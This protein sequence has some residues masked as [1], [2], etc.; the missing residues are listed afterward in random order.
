MGVFSN[1]WP[2]GGGVFLGWT[3][4]ANDAANVFGTAVG[5]RIVRWRTASLLCA[6]FV[7][8]GAFLQGSEG[9]RTLSSITHQSI[10]TAVIVSVAAALTGALMTYLKI[11]VSTSQ[12]VV[13]AILGIGLAS[14]DTEYGGLIKVVL[15][16]IGTPIGSM[17]FA[18]LSFEGLAFFLRRVPL[19]LLSRDRFLWMGLLVC[20]CYGAYALGANNVAN[21]TGMFSGLI[22]GVTD[23]VLTLVGGLAIAG[24]TLSFSKRV[25]LNVGRGIMRLD[26]FTALAAVLGMSITVHVFA[27]IG[28]PVSTSQGIVGSILGIGLL[29]GAQGVHFDVLK[30]I[31][32]GWVLS[33][34]IS[35]VLSAAGYAIFI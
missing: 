2:L 33:P 29:R 1:F 17:F 16:W 26:A 10:P 6:F 20:G 8:L 28:A 23:E 34:G 9:I 21:T 32:V 24:G 13:G 12:C 22:P 4:G 35:L 25:M 15:C 11:P 14:R 18:I 27:I 30:K 5:A 31:A 19:G 3:L 7:I